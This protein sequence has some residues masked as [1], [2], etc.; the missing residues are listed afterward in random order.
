VKTRPHVVFPFGVHVTPAGVITAPVAVLFLA[1]E[2]NEQEAPEGRPA[3][4][5]LAKALPSNVHQL[6]ARRSA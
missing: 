2:E 5:G 3:R 1:A 6:P 4:P